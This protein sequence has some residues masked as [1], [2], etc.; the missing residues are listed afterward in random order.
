M[1]RRIANEFNGVKL[2]E[3]GRDLFVERIESLGPE[4]DGRRN[5]VEL[6]EFIRFFERADSTAEI[7][8]EYPDLINKYIDTPKAIEMYQRFAREARTVLNRYPI[9]SS[10]M[11]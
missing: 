2:N 4:D 7:L 5:F 8:I 9:L 1:I 10:I 6:A 3:Y 11:S